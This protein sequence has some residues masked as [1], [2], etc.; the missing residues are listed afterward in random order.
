MQ[1]TDANKKKTWRETLGVY[2][3]LPIL[4]VFLLGIAS[5]FPLLLVGSTL[6]TRLHESGIDIKTIGVFALVGV[7]YTYKFLISPCVDAIQLPF[8]K[9][10][11]LH[12]KSWCMFS[13]LMLVATLTAMAWCDPAAHIELMG[14]LALLTATFSALQDIVIDAIRIEIARK[15]A[16]AAASA[17]LV[18]GYRVGMLLAGAGALFLAEVLPWDL[19]YLVAAEVMGLCMLATLSIRRLVGY[20]EAFKKDSDAAKLEAEQAAQTG[21][22]SE[23]HH[24]WFYKAFYAPIADFM[25]RRGAIKILAFIALFKLGEAM[26]GTL[27]MP[28]YLELGF[29]KAEIA[30]I[31]KVFGVVATIFG[32]FVGGLVVKR[33][34]IVKALFLCGSLQLASNFCYI[35]LS[36][37]GHSNLVLTLSITIENVTGGM[38]TAA[39]VAFMSQLVNVRFTAT[40]YALL[41]SLSSVGRT[42]V[43]ASTGFLVAQ[44]G[45]NGFYIFTVFCGLP[46]L[47]LLYL[48]AP[49]IGKKE[50]PKA[51][52]STAP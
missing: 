14:I 23:L 37:A 32:A 8:L 9:T 5:G 52:P 34:N 47:A 3:Q 22:P 28:F 39:F 51:F 16:Q 26:A 6:L 24:S 43:S 46:G 44:M 1:G 48:V 25:K 33:M 18:A 19:V 40:Q 4:W 12:R 30:T 10:H 17:S 49:F 11:L 29:S 7:P 13:Q 45:W 35:W 21:I 27:S 36:Y 41:S 42:V 15:D 31:S 20:D 38:N 2:W 50:T